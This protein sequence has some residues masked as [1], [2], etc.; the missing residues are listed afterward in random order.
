MAAGIP[1][2]L[3]QVSSGFTV[4]TAH[5][6]PTTD[7]RLDW[8]ALARSGTTLVILMGARKAGAVSHRL[9]AAGMD[10]RTPVAVVH[11][12]T[13]DGES[14]QRTTL[15]GL[16]SIPVANPSTIVVGAVAAHDL[17]RHAPRYR[18]EPVRLLT[19]GGVTR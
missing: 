2:T 19:H 4:V 7:P 18:P 9:Q 13:T 16:A 1:V 8:D 15:A 11:A 14:V 3:R 5:H 10:P 12:A 6:D 17:L